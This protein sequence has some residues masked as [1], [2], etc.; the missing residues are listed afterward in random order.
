MNRYPVW[1]YIVIAVALLF[2][3]TYTAPNF[4]G[5]APAV[6]IS[7]QRP[8]VKVDATL[9]TRIETSLKSAGVAY[10]AAYVE[11][12]GL[13]VTAR[14]RLA[15]TDTQIRARDAL[16]TALN[17]DPK[18]PTYVVALSLL[19]RSPRW[20]ASV[21]ALPMYLGLDLR[22]GVHFL[23][24]VNTAEAVN[25]RLEAL[26]GDLRTLL[27]EKDVRHAGITR[28]GERIEIRFREAETRTKGENVIRD[29][30]GTELALR[31]DASGTDLLLVAT[32]S[33]AAAKAVADSALKQNITTLHNRI[34][35]LG[36]AEPVIQQQGADRVVVQL[37]GVQDTARAKDIIGRTATLEARLVDFSAEG[38]AAVAGGAPVPFG[39]E[40]FTVGRGAP[41]VLKKEIIF[42]GQ[43]LQGAQ[44]TFDENQRP[45]VSI[46]LN[47]SAGRH[48]RKVSR[49]N[50]KKPMAIVLFEKG[51]GE[52]LTVAT[53][54]D[55]LG[56]RFRITGLE[57][58]Q[59]ANDLALLL[60]A[61]AL[62]APMDIIEERTI[63]PSLGKENIDRGFRA[64]AFGFLAIAVFMIF[65]YRVFGLISVAGLTV[66]IG[67]LV[68]L[69]SL[70]QATL[71]LPGI[72]AVALTLG[73][74]ID[75]NVLI[76]ERV[77]EE[78][79]RGATAQQAI[80]QGYDR[81][82]A[83]ILDSNVTTLIAGIFLF[84]LGSGPIRGFAVVHCL[85]ILTSIF[86]A[87][88]VSRGIVNLVYGS[89]R[90]LATLS[91][92]QVWTGGK[93]A[94]LKA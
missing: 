59:M 64:T 24:Q 50:I 41:V 63:G 76:N 7:S 54:Q 65:Y 56:S 17:P 3:A 71:T 79:R 18:D 11:T 72:A 43:Q 34:N 45:A 26:V 8:T 4:F 89:R 75:A 20:L 5:E 47:E 93:T 87:V 40:R 61:G 90:R 13:N 49:E 82:F 42:S 27:R 33:P 91:V 37:P 53:I 48:L 73:M 14:V 55:E 32:L 62:A 39:S 22:G 69:L 36:V 30:F 25:K 60:R 28:A 70:L 23:M 78:L 1:K 19:S 16:E 44:A 31:E 2:G 67:L 15:D 86:S 58:P 74:A 29:S 94:A 92:G 6:Q 81:A 21:R 46:D 52:V 88:F 9:L 84:M 35:E 38:Q 12:V 51:R 68:G 83:T 10:E 77:R 66:N 85:G 80:T 57:S